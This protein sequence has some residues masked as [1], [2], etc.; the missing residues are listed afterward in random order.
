[1]VRVETESRE[2]MGK[3][4]LKTESKNT[5]RKIIIKR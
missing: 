4:I 2:S 3:K 1:M 5:K